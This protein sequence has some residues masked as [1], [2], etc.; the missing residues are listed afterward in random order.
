M[1]LFKRYEVHCFSF[2]QYST[3]FFIIIVKH[4]TTFSSVNEGN[5]YNK[6]NVTK[7]AFRNYLSSLIMYFFIAYEFE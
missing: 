2:E 6:N 4:L 3:Q 1:K 7:I 5:F